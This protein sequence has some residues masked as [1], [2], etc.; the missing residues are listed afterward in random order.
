MKRGTAKEVRD[1]VCV[2]LVEQEVLAHL[3]GR[4][5][6]VV[7]G[8]AGTRFQRGDTV[9]RFFPLLNGAERWTA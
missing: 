4:R 1:A 6:E 5:P 9:S 3:A 8:V 2:Y 7:L